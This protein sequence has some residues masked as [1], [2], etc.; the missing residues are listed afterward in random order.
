MKSILIAGGT[1]LVGSRLSALLEAHGYQVRLL[2]RKPGMVDG[3]QAFSWKPSKG[4]IDPSALE[5]LHAV[6]NLAGAGIADARWTEARKK[7]IIDSRV[8]GTHLLAQKLSELPKPPKVYL[9]ASAMGIYGDRGDAWMEEQSA[10]GN[11]FLSKSTLAWEQAIDEVEQRGIR[12]VRLRIGIVLSTKG[13]ALEKM[14]LPAKFRLGTYFGNGRQWYSWIHIDDLCQMF[15]FALE[16]EALHGA[17]NAV[18]PNP[19]RNRAF[20]LAIGEALDKPVLPLPAPA[21]GLRLA[22]GEMA[23]VILNST[24]VR[25]DKIQQAGFRFQFPELVPALRDV[26]QKQI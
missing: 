16:N 3:R 5:G 7:L 23:S 11:D 18:S 6:I 22:M 26:L 15:L 20:T 4:E 9:A 24:R 13:G 19:E 2:S 25:A 8:D 12:T 21:F 17:Y 14:M 10:P 1:G